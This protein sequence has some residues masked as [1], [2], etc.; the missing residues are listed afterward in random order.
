[1]YYHQAV[2]VEIYT[3]HKFSSKFLGATIPVQIW[4]DCTELPGVGRVYSSREMQEMFF[5]VF[6]W[7]SSGKPMGK[8]I[9][10]HI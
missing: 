4:T 7:I 2:A 5:E 8:T 6:G 10:I 1:L 3:F 9:G